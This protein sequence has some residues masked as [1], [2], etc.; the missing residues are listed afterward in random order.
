M[1][2]G[3]NKSK[4]LSITI[5][6]LLVVSFSGQNVLGYGGPPAQ[7][8]SGNYTILQ[9]REASTRLVFSLICLDRLQSDVLA[10]LGFDLQTSKR[11]STMSLHSLDF[12]DYNQGGYCE[13]T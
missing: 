3:V 10:L 9:K 1:A 5:A 11:Y 13:K 8:S 2:K 4:I 7:S 12:S 6:S